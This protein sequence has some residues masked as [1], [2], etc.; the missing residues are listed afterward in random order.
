[1]FSRM[2]KKQIAKQE[3]KLE[4]FLS[5]HER[6]VPFPD[7]VTLTADFPCLDGEEAIYTVDIF[8]PAGVEET[9]PVV[10]DIHG[11]GFLLGKKEV[12]RLFCADFCKRGFLVLSAEYPLAPRADIFSILRILSDLMRKIPE[13][14]A[15]FGGDATR[16]FLVGDSA[17]AW[18][19]LYLAAMQR[20]ER[21]AAT[22]GVD[23]AGTPRVSALGLQSGMFY[24]QKFDS[25]GLFL[26]SLIYG[27]KFRAHPFFPYANPEH[28]EILTHL[29][30]VFLVTGRGD[31]LR[32]YS[33]RY[34]K[35]LEKA[36]ADL[37]FLDKK[38]E[39]PLPHAFPAILPE[40]PVSGEANDAMARFFRSKEAVN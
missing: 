2:I 35:M 24:T 4:R 40:L 33:R 5:R 38:D 8:R 23:L 28:E 34:A 18:L 29:P 20:S 9:L 32:R 15:E 6:E 25:V 1:M 36:N 11:G 14:S 37:C 16:L 22:A 26:P 19:A 13:V 17:G 31:F 21:L 30:P 7:D 10:L 3:E 27:K 39:K 12:N